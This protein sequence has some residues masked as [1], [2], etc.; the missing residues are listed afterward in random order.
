[1]TIAIIAITAIVSFIC[2][3]NKELFHKLAFIPSLIRRDFGANAYRF[4]SHAF[5]HG[6][7]AH[8]GFNMV[9]LYFFGPNLEQ[10]LSSVWEYLFFYLS[11][12]V[13]SSAFSYV[14]QKDNPAYLSI[15]A[16]GAVSAV[17]MSLVLYAPWAT[18]YI[19]FFLPIYYVLYAVFFIIYSRY[20]DK[21]GT[22]NIAHDVHLVGAVYGLLYMAILHPSALTFFWQEIMNPP[23][24][25]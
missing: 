9:T 12:V 2:F 22:D 6:D 24:L 1:M 21:R 18:I 13:V 11:A 16:S 19:S 15:G 25:N 10:V 4:I 20:M 14:R 5:V 7:I 23:F 3:N 8:L 17:L